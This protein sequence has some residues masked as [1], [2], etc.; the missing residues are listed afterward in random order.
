MIMPLS[1][2]TQLIYC[3]L[4]NAEHP[5]FLHENGDVVWANPAACTLFGYG[6]QEMMGMNSLDLAAPQEKT[7]LVNNMTRR[8]KHQEAPLRYTCNALRKDG[9]PFVTHVTVCH[10]EPDADENIWMLLLF[11][12]NNS[13]LWDFATMNSNTI[14]HWSQQYLKNI[15]EQ[16]YS[17]LHEEQKRE[18][19]HL[20]REYDGKLA[21]IQD[22]IG[23]L[24]QWKKAVINLL[25]AAGG[26]VA[27]AILSKMVTLPW[28]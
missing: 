28:Q 9:T 23:R 13:P 3:M 25:Y 20:K 5:M 12:E 10:V 2:L 1:P 8:K 19:A 6:F 15:S 17:V 4:M 18:M 26:V 14:H 7:R 22:T 21:I 27:T 24:A 16:H 11:D